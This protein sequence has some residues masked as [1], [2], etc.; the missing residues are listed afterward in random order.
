MIWLAWE[1]ITATWRTAA[2]VL[3][4]ATLA[5]VAVFGARHWAPGTAVTGATGAEGGKWRDRAHHAGPAYRPAP[6]TYSYIDGENAD[7]TP[8]VAWPCAPIRWAYVH[9]D[10]APAGGEVLVARAFAAIQRSSGGRLRFTRGPDLDGWA[11]E[12]PLPGGIAAGWDS[13]RDFGGAAGV[14][15]PQWSGDTI[16]S[17]VARLNPARAGVG[18]D[19]ELIAAHE[20]SHALGLDHVAGSGRLMSMSM[21]PTTRITATDGNLWAWLAASCG[22]KTP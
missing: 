22:G 10:S 11:A 15:G 19:D 18:P 7:G 5:A 21:T 9:D 6:G 16:E 3:V 2:A 12:Q 8:R 17:G 14:G 4:A 1:A 13:G 20:I